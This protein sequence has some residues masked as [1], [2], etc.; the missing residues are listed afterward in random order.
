MHYLNKAST[1]AR[2]FFHSDVF[3]FILLASA[4]S[5]F[6]TD[7]KSLGRIDVGDKLLSSLRVSEMM[8]NLLVSKVSACSTYLLVRHKIVFSSVAL[9]TM[10]WIKTN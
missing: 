4:F 7:G 6:T 8:L 2:Y 3:I 9:C 1:C 5:K 10:K